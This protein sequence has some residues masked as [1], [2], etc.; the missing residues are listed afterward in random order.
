[1]ESM[2]D[3]LLQ[4]PLFQGLA[5]DDF[6][7]ILEKVKLRFAK[8]Q[9]GEVLAEAG[10]TCGALLFILRGEA[11]STTLSP[12]GDYRLTEYLPAGTLIEPQA[13]FGMHTHYAATYVAR[14]QTHTVSIDKSFVMTELFHHHIFLLNYLNM[15]T[16][17]A[18][19]LAWR[20]WQRMGGSA[21][22]RIAGFLLSL[23]DRPTGTK[24][25]QIRLDTLSDIVGESRA[26]TARALHAMEERGWLKLTSRDTL[27]IADA[28]QLVD[29]MAHPTP[30]AQPS[31]A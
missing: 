2:F 30:G 26:G 24:L 28:A 1:M 6:T 13:L 11:V 19:T 22:M 4:L 7:A 21:E 31:G 23:L 9:P 14:V 27:V 17:R 8:H 15:V 16:N 12:A 3:T 25:F 18:Q 10:Q 29:A 20:R 5:Q